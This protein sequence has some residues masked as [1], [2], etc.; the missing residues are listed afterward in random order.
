MDRNRRELTVSMD[1]DGKE[2]TLPYDYLVITTGTQYSP[3]RPKTG[4][5][6]NVGVVSIKG[7]LEDRHCLED[8]QALIGIDGNQE[9][10][11]TCTFIHVGIQ[12]TCTCNSTVIEAHVYMYLYCTCVFYVHCT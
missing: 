11:C 2:C 1:D 7:D 8:A 4:D 3:D 12:C 6:P 10:T 9:T 5:I